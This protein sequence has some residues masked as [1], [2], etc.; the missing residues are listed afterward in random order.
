VPAATPLPRGPS[1]L[2]LYGA[3]DLLTALGC[4]VCRYA[5]EASDRYLGWFAVEGHAQPDLIATLQESLGMCARHARGVMSQPGAAGRLTPVYRHVLIGVRGR[6]A[7]RTWPIA[8]CPACRHDGAATG[9]ALDTLLDGLADPGTLR[10]C[11]DLGG[12]CLP[13]LRTTARRAA[14]G[15]VVS[16]AE[17]LRETLTARPALHEQLGGTDYDA[18]IRVALRRRIP[19]SPAPMPDLCEACLAAARAERD[20]LAQVTGVSRHNADDAGALCAVH[21]ADAV[22][23]ASSDQR[24]EVLARQCSIIKA[25]AQSRGRRPA[26]RRPARWLRPSA[27][28][29]PCDDCPACQ[30]SRAAALQTL[31]GACRAI[32]R[33]P[34]AG[35][36]HPDLCLRHQVISRSVDQPAGR[37]M[38]SRALVAAD[39]L[40]AELAEDFELSTWAGRQDVAQARES[41][42]WRRAAAFLNGGVFTGLNT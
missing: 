37:A 13:H 3:A 33:M 34:A 23:L 25:E 4:P 30:Q 15:I 2:S 1:V 40:I 41:T 7:G 20:S 22:A 16:L 38:N 10:R 21:L 8:P 28:R 18:E 12:V 42:A 6:L 14:R 31:Q 19:A 11:Q 5:A 39:E 17:T 27:R 26:A 24:H 36:H 35:G 29:D 32:R 9:R